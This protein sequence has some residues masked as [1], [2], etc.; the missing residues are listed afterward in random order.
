MSNTNRSE[1]EA[2][3]RNRA[4]RQ[5]TDVIGSYWP[6]GR[7]RQR[8]A[9]TA[10]STEVGA[11]P[12]SARVKAPVVTTLSLLKSRTW[13]GVS[14]GEGSSCRKIAWTVA[15]ENGTE[16]NKRLRAVSL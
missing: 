13:S 9:G 10:A 11:I 8:Y 3:C 1:T 4:P 2:H 7:K 16:I 15:M 14:R 5:R 6:F 12:R